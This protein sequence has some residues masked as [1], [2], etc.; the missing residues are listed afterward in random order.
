MCPDFCFSFCLCVFLYQLL[1]FSKVL[2]SGVWHSP[3]ILENAQP[4]ISNITPDLYFISSLSRIPTIC[5]LNC[6]RLVHNSLVFGSFF[7]LLSIFSDW[8][9]FINLSSVSL[10]LSI[11]V[12]NLLISLLMVFFICFSFVAFSFYCFCNFHLSVEV[13]PLY[14]VCCPILLLESL[15]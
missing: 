3:L 2:R 14:V 7:S 8:I 4:Y 12:L 15:T 1:V 5:M 10:I 13:Y 11:A 6:L 9:L